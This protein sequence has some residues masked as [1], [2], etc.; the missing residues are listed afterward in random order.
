MAQEELEI[1]NMSDEEF[2]AL[3]DADPEIGSDDGEYDELDN[4]EDNNEE[5]TNDFEDTDHADDS[6]EEDDNDDAQTNDGIDGEDQDSDEDDN[7]ESDDDE[8]EENAQVDEDS[9]N[10]DE[11]GESKDDDDDSEGDSDDAKDKTDTKT[12]DDGQKSDTEEIDYKQE[13]EKFKGFYDEVTSEF[14]ANGK[15]MRGFDDP[16]KII[17]AQQMAAG[18]SEKMAGFKQYR[19]YMSPLKERGMLED[20]TK[21][22]LA[23]NLIDGDKEA[24]KQ[25]MKNLE[26]DPLELEMDEIQYE[27][28]RQTRSQT[29][30]AIDDMMESAA[31]YGVQEK[32]HGI[33]GGQW[34]DDSR[35][36]LINN[37]Q[38]A[39]DLVDHMQS[40]AYDAVQ[41]RIA[42]IKR[43]D[44]D[45]RFT[46][47]SDIQQ[48]KS[49][50][51]QLE[52]EYQDYLKTQQATEAKEDSVNTAKSVE[53]EKARIAKEQQEATYKAQVEQNNKKASE[54]RKKAASVSKKK[55]K[56]KPVKKTFDPMALDDDAFSAELDKLMY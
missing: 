32:I 49:A 35:L 8:G 12:D 15:K 39:H 34:D 27:G 41:D 20:Q 47:M 42:E 24:L 7:D 10:A 44:V 56:K 5:D 26:I 51:A 30:L 3:L 40:G 48:Y 31:R 25:H 38:S 53:E 33:I 4:T 55:V 21:F 37:P 11:D 19:P 17:Q 36:E 43:I 28:K 52:S 6:S 23:M 22:D 2:E 9:L 45:G 54:A 14:T 13:Y 1:D 46:S 50:A 29:Q 18:F 16:K